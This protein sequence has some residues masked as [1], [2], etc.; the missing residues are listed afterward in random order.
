[1]QKLFFRPSLL[2]AFL[3]VGGATLAAQPARADYYIGNDEVTIDNFV[4][5]DEGW[6]ES[7]IDD[8]ENDPDRERYCFNAGTAG[9]DLITD[10]SVCTTVIYDEGAEIDIETAWIGFNETHLLMA[11][12]SVAPM[13]SVTDADG[14]FISLYDSNELVSRG[15][16]TLPNDFEHDFV[17][18]FDQNPVEGEESFDWYVVAHVNYSFGSGVGP[19]NNSSFF[20]IYQEEGTTAGYQADE[21]IAVADVS[22]ADAETAVITDPSQIDAIFEL[23]ANIEVFYQTTEF[24]VGDEVGFR[25]ET[26]S[27]TGDETPSEI[28]TFVDTAVTED[29]V[30]VGNGARQFAGRFAD[31]FSKGIF[32]I[33][34]DSDQSELLEVTAYDK[35]FG[36]QVAVGDVD[37]DGELEIVTLPFKAMKDP[38][39]K[40]FD[41]NGKLEA[42]GSVPKK[43]GERLTNY[44]LAVG[45]LDASGREEIVFSNVKSS[46]VWLDV[47]RL[48]DEGELS[49]V[50]QYSDPEYAGYTVGSWV[51]IANV[52]TS[53][54]AEEIVTASF[55]G[56]AQVDLWNL[57]ESSVNLTVTYLEISAIEGYNKGLHIAPAE[58]GVWISTHGPK[59]KAVWHEWV[60]S[61]GNLD[62][63]DNQFLAGLVGD[64]TANTNAVWASRFAKKQVMKVKNNGD[65]VYRLPVQSK[66][67]FLDLIDLE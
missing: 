9:W 33:Y 41:L 37:A 56:G 26:H 5:A 63:T 10:P 16:T 12:Q 55:K 8:G 30:V 54:E 57:D 25:L 42:S 60:E 1:M 62:A 14:S 27:V 53:T 44:H 66:G 48:T 51:K 47:F 45:N 13:Y 3:A 29:A 61:K 17:F 36:V 24:A 50:A 28:V 34:A 52:D 38:K 58:G 49:R 32:R 2:V 46:G 6:G 35:N 19:G 21:D 22:V 23:R 65:L 20:Q 59:A 43:A 18:S 4:T 11:Y 39:W 64:V 40:V 67:S 15:I 31:K 7:L